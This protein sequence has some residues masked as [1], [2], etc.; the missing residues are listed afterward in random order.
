M[1]VEVV[2]AVRNEAPGIPE[3]VRAM[4]AIPLP[5]TVSLG[6]LFV[7]DSSTDGTVDVIAEHAAP[8]VRGFTLERGLGQGPAI[9]YGAKQSTA[10]AVV[11]MDGD[12]SH[13]LSAIPAMVDAFMAGAPVVQC[14]RTSSGARP[15]LRE[16]L[17]TWFGPVCRALTGFDFRKQNVYFRLVGRSV[18]ERLLTKPQLW[19]FLRV[20]WN[21]F[22]VP[23]TELPIETLE[24]KK[25]HSKYSIW[26]LLRFAFAGM[27]CVIS[28]PRLLAL[29]SLFVGSSLL[30]ALRGPRLL[31]VIPMAGSGV[32]IWQY[33]LV[34]RVEPL[35][36]LR[37][38]PI[39]ALAA[40]VAQGSALPERGRAGTP[41]TVSP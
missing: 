25:G 2:V 12:G 8:G 24:R 9:Y 41:T 10:D 6:L 23:V 19:W 7:E 13:P 39:E 28:L 14:C 1:T 18:L 15:R 38:A 17:S 40:P 36:A 33:V 31:A 35:A 22:G 37:G 16:A 26:R 32:L 11:M 21:H 30:L 20:P 3:F 5:P 4:R 29:S 34:R 27:M